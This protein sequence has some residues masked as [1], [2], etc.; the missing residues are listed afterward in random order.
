MVILTRACRISVLALVNLVKLFFKVELVYI[1]YAFLTVVFKCIWR[2]F[3]QSVNY[4]R[5]LKKSED[6]GLVYFAVDVTNYK[7][8]QKSH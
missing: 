2:G 5:K 8:G 3:F 7:F 1:K 4:E 6:S